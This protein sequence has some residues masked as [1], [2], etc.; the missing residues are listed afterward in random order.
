MERIY[1]IFYILGWILGNIVC[2]FLA[3]TFVLTVVL[4][5]ANVLQWVF[6]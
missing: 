1:N 5:G 6:A 2:V 3:V 4:A